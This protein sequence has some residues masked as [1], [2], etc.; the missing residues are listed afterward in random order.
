MLCDRTVTQRIA[1]G[2]AVADGLHK[3]GVLS[4]AVG[5][6]YAVRVVA[7]EVKTLLRVKQHFEAVVALQTRNEENKY[8]KLVIG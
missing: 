4:G 7:I 5:T 6:C 2:V 3:V 8:L 1:F